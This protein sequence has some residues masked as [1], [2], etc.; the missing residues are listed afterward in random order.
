MRAPDANVN[1][2]S[3][4][5]QWANHRSCTLFDREILLALTHTRAVAR[6]LRI[7]TMTRL[8][9]QASEREGETNERERV[10]NKLSVE[11]EH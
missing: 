4:E 3:S 1:S 6:V 7:Q 11:S 2:D 8:E 5:F 10:K 9:K